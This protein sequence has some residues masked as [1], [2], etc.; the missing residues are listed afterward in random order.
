MSLVDVMWP[1]VLRAL[2]FAIIVAACS[3]DVPG[4][5]V[6]DGGTGDPGVYVPGDT[7]L[8]E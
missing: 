3:D 7:P 4:A 1:A 8:A 5:G 2:A 6:P